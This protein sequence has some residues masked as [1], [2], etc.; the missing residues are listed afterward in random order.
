MNAKTCKKLRRLAGLSGA[1]ALVAGIL[2]S[3]TRY[4]PLEYFERW[5][6]VYDTDLDAHGN[7]PTNPDGT[8]KT[9]RFDYLVVKP[10]HV[11]PACPRGRYL[12]LKRAQSVGRGVTLGTYSTTG[13]SIR[14]SA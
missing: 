10:I 12:D 4:L 9:K 5:M 13:L 8:P 1:R 6:E 7:L 11:D 3:P 2:G 14:V